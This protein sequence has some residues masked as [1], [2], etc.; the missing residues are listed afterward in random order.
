MII[1][2]CLYSL[3]I[4]NELYHKKIYVSYIHGV[5]GHSNTLEKLFFCRAKPLQIF[6]DFQLSSAVELLSSK[7]TLV[8]V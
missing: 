7:T 2:Y 6:T 3:K 1:Q 5:L 8:V 4:S